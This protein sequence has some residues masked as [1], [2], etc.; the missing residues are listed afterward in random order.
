LLPLV[1]VVAGARTDP[2]IADRATKIVASWGKTPVRSTDSPGFIVNRVNRP[3]TIEALRM[4]EAGEARIEDIDAALRGDGFPLGPF[5]LMDLVGLDVNLAAATEVWEGLG[6]PER[7]R[8]SPIQSWL[9]EAGRLGRK[10]G[11]G[12]YRYDA[13]HA[14]TPEPL[15]ED[16]AAPA[17]R[18]QPRRPADV[19]GRIRLA[20]AAEAIHARDSGVAS[21]ADIDTALRLGAAHPEGPFAWARR[22]DPTIAT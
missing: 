19:V 3:F 17:R 15:P 10:S 21:E 18:G 7:L 1:E 20:I 8:P 9:V 2:R 6:Q 16:M 11:R 22:H 14:P 5:E 12:F 13:G 4:L